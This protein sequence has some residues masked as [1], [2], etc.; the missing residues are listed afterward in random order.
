MAAVTSISNILINLS[1]YQ[2]IISLCVGVYFMDSTI[3]SNV[4]TR[5]EV[6]RLTNPRT[7]PQII[8]I[9]FCA[10]HI[11]EIIVLVVIRIFYL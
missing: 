4:V 10:S 6:E 1:M 2:F 9:I 8:L 11:I 3:Y 7:N 5:E